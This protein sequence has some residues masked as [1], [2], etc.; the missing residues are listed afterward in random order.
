MTAL[1]SVSIHSCVILK[2]L[3][4]SEEGF[5][6]GHCMRPCFVGANFALPLPSFQLGERIA[7][8]HLFDVFL[9]LLLVT[10]KSTILL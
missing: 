6:L 3:L 2:S 8:I 1:K 10:R 9:G 7:V 5:E 4:L